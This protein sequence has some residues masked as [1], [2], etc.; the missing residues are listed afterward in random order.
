MPS[1]DITSLR[2]KK[3]RFVEILAHFYRIKTNCFLVYRISARTKRYENLKSYTKGTYHLR[4]VIATSDSI[5]TICAWT[6]W[7]KKKFSQSRLRNCFFFFCF[8]LLVQ[9]STLLLVSHNG[10][11]SINKMVSSK[12]YFV[13]VADYDSL[14]MT[15]IKK[16]R[17]KITFFFLGRKGKALGVSFFFKFQNSFGEWKA[18]KAE[19]ST[20]LGVPWN[21]N[22]RRHRTKWFPPIWMAWTKW[23]SKWFI[24]SICVASNFVIRR[25]RIDSIASSAKKV[26]ALGVYKELM[27]VWTPSGLVGMST[28]FLKGF[29]WLQINNKL[30]RLTF[31]HSKHFFNCFFKEI[32]MGSS[33]ERM[34]H[35]VETISKEIIF[36][37]YKE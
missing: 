15:P 3:N 31:S 27:C 12:T 24:A 8:F 35:H 11:P 34:K 20:L 2:R 14:L 13:Y 17:R 19:Y 6:L 9:N 28:E 30:E 26:F 23:N 4:A 36:F 5:Y 22:F 37:V 21:R 1:D 33:S 16:D 7:T 18:E 25:H 10:V 32:L 29:G